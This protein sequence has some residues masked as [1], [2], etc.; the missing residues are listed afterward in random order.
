MHYT[1]HTDGG[2]RGNPG[3]AGIA[4]V[5]ESEGEKICL[6]KYIGVATNNQAEYRALTL[7]LEHILKEFGQESKVISAYCF[8]DSELVVRQLLGDYKVKEPT[9]KELFTK[10]L[11]L[12]HQFHQID[13]CHIPRSENIEADKLVNEAIDGQ[14]NT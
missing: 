10:V 14:K 1:I 8:L 11:T 12:C 6:K 13:F 9:I 5:I 3:Q 4:A 2:A 7:A